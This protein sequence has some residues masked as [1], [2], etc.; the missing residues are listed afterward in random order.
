MK[1]FI[2]IVIFTTLALYCGNYVTGAFF[3]GLDITKTHILVIVALS[4]LYFFLGPVSKILLLPTKGIISTLIYCLLTTIILYIFTMVIPGFAIKAVVLS[5]L[6][7]FGF[8]IPSANLTSLWST[9]VSSFIVG[10]VYTF[11]QSLCRKK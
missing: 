7:I 10:I 1:Y 5:G 8:V 6:K 3:Y 2:R 9:V 4:V 11:L